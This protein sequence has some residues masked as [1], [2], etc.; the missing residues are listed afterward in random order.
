MVPRTQVKLAAFQ[1]KYDK[2]SLKIQMKAEL[3]DFNIAVYVLFQLSFVSF[4]HCH[5]QIKSSGALA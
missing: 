4:L 2:D 3:E 5:F 1:L